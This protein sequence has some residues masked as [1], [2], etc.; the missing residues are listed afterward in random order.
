MST[1]N[2]SFTKTLSRELLTIFLRFAES[3]HKLLTIIFENFLKTIIYFA[4]NFA[5]LKIVSI[6]RIFT[7]FS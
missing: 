7:K 5:K 3:A 1:Q 4:Q 6:F 2:F